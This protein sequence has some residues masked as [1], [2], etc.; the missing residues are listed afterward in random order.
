MQIFWKTLQSR[1]LAPLSTENPG[2]TAENLNFNLWD[3][4]TLCDGLFGNYTANSQRAQISDFL[5]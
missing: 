4:M 5:F 3:V 1:L 2:S